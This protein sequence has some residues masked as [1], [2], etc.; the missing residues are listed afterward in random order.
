MNIIQETDNQQPSLDRNIF[1]GSET[2]PT[3]ST[4]KIVEAVPTLSDN[5]EGNDIVQRN[6]AFFK[7]KQKANLM[8]NNKFNYS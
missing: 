1:E 3:G 7:Y 2:I 4:Q 5:A 6:N 8:F